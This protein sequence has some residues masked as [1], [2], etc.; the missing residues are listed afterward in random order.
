MPESIAQTQLRL[1]EF[2]Q[3]NYPL[4]DCSPGTAVSQLVISLSSTLD[5]EIY[6]QITAFSQVSSIQQVLAST[7]PTFTPTIDEISSNYNVSRSTGTLSTG[8]IQIFLAKNQNVTVPQAAQFISPALGLVY[9][10]T[11]PYTYSLNNNSINRFLPIF[12]QSTGIYYIIVPVQAVAVG[13]Q[14]QV[15]D[16]SSFSVQSN[17]TNTSI[18]SL[19][20][21]GN[22]SSGSSEQSDQQ[23]IQQLQVGL[24]NVSLTSQN[25]IT[26]YLTNNITGFQNCNVIG[27]SDALMFRSKE[28]LFGINTFGCADV[29]CRTSFGPENLTI[30]GMTG[31]KVSTG[32]WQLQVANTVCPGFYGVD[33]ILPTPVN[34]VIIG[35]S[36]PITS[37]TYG[38]SAI[39][40]STNQNQISTVEDA[41]FTC[42]QNALVTFSYT[43]TPTVS[44]GSTASFNVDFTYQP[45]LSNIQS[46]FLADNTRLI[47]ADILAKAVV[48][49]FCNVTIN[50]IKQNSTDT[51]TSVGVPTLQ[52]NIFNYI[53]GLKF[54]SSV[55]ASE[56]IALCMALPIAR[57][58][59]PIQMNG[60]IFA[61]SGISVNISSSDSLVIP[62]DIDNGYSPDNTQFFI[63]YSTT[64]QISNIVVNLI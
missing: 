32:V 29:Y 58:Q 40:N 53:N 35:G 11:Q 64:E 24:T 21:Y 31:T 3:E 34:N 27:A 45:D 26:N 12:T 28:N 51:P 52:Q 18:I 62:T 48:P 22:F 5:N 43:E 54:G 17:F 57:V 6:S 4:I 47:C 8:N 7:V 49:C 13:S 37:T 56:I 9:Q 14:Y 23:L 39:P 1:T 10:T 46:I 19:Q 38:Y 30:V 60:N 42:Y 61:P 59:L 2:I 33:S 63:N 16:K 20:A 36:L 41:R 44:N 55:T 50:L 25:A 15:S